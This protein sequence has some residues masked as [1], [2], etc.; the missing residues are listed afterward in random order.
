MLV[1]ISSILL[2]DTDS[3]ILSV[4]CNKPIKW[5]DLSAKLEAANR[6][7]WAIGGCSPYD[8]LIT[9]IFSIRPRVKGRFVKFVEIQMP[10]PA[11]S[12]LGQ[13]I[14]ARALYWCGI[15]R[16]TLFLTNCSARVAAPG[17]WLFGIVGA[18]ARMILRVPQLSSRRE[19]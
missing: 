1:P 19:R 18:T 11:R 5:R 17:R 9:D 2:W 10:R 4:M 14:I 15:A 16:R 8:S 6:C 12:Y 3:K 13:A 7:R